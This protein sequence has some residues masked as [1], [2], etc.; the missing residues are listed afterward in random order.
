MF[1]FGFNNNSLV[2]LTDNLKDSTQITK[3]SSEFFSSV[4][5]M[6]G[7]PQASVLGPLLF[8]IYINDLVY[9]AD[10]LSCLSSDET[11]LWVS[12]D[13]WSQSI[14]DFSMKWILFQDW[15]KF[16]QL[17]I[18]LSKRKLMFITKQSSARLSFLI[19]IIFFSISMLIVLNS[20]NLSFSD[21]C[22]FFFTNLF[23]L[24]K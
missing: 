10:M 17:T 11:T 13:N 3:I 14:F 22:S 5:L 19:F 24:M 6:I 9:L 1:Q 12:G 8:L 23:I 21:F 15:V 16:N 2:P 20:L 7:V 4:D 18:N